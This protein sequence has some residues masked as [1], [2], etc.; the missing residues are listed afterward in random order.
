MTDFLPNIKIDL[1]KDFYLVTF[2]P[3]HETYNKTLA[4][5]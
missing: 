2:L 3:R 4:N 5:V 1:S